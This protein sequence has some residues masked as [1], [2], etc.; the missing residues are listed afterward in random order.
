MTL[1]LETKQI[2]EIWDSGQSQRERLIRRRDYYDGKHKILQKPGKRHGGKPYNKIVSNWVRRL[3]DRH[4]G[5]ATS[6]AFNLTVAEGESLEPL[7][8]YD[9]VLRDNQLNTVDSL[10]FRDSNRYGY[11]VEE[12]SFDGKKI[13]ITNHDPI[14]WHFIIDE[15]GV[16]V[17]AIRRLELQKDTVFEDD[18]LDKNL[19]LY[20][21]Y[22]DKTITSYKSESAGTGTSQALTTQTDLEQTGQVPHQYGQLPVIQ[23]SANADNAPLIT[24]AFISLNDAY[25]TAVSGMLDDHEG[26][27]DA[28][29][30]FIGIAADELTRKDKESNKSQIQIMRELQAIVLADKDSSANFITRA[31][32]FEKI[33]F[34]IKR[35][36]RLIHTMGAA[37]DLEEIVG[38]TGATSG[39]ALKLQFQ[40]MVERAGENK[41]H[42][43][44]SMRQRID[45]I[46]TIWEIQR[47]PILEN[48]NVIV[49]FEIPE[50]E[51]EIWNSIMMLEPLLTRPALAAL[52]PS[53]ENPEQATVAKAEERLADAS[54][55]Q[56]LGPPEAPAAPGEVPTIPS[57]VPPAQEINDQVQVAEAAIDV[58]AQVASALAL[59]GIVLTPEQLEELV[60]ELLRA[61]RS[62]GAA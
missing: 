1:E 28:F 37:P 8:Q 3:V 14:E 41:K 54:L 30:V 6:K 16:N 32:P 7:R 33:Q 42:I 15:F 4:T 47:K 12:H 51:N 27:V 57:T 2:L 40:A 29:L 25:N 36:Q 61:I 39:I 52:V 21:F 62:R 56:P 17:G 48:Y 9:E 55:A 38:T 24:D 43:N 10:Q 13:I 58:E 11:G 60:A 49:T 45:L 44:A 59:D 19:V 20:W 5:F 46:N 34:I 50:N 18:V 22:N 53:I 31:L 26:D 35:L 23:W